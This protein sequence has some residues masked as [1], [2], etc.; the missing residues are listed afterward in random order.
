MQ[1]LQEKL[2]VRVEIHICPRNA[3][4]NSRFICYNNLCIIENH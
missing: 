1:A 4:L 3:I 2:S